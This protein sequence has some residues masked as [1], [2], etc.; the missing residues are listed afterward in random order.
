[1]VNEACRLPIR[2]FGYLATN[3][4]AKTTFG[5]NGV[6]ADQAMVSHFNRGEDIANNT[7][8]KNFGVS[9]AEDLQ[10]TQGCRLASPEVTYHDQG[11]R[12]QI[13]N[14]NQ[15]R[16]AW[17]SRDVRYVER[18]GNKVRYC[19]VQFYTDSRQIVTLSEYKTFTDKFQMGLSAAGITAQNVQS[20]L[21]GGWGPNHAHQMN[22]DNPN[23]KGVHSVLA[24]Y[25]GHVH[26]LMVWL[27]SPRPGLYGAI[28]TSGEI[29][30]PENSG[31]MTICMVKKMNADGRY[32]GNLSMKFNI[33][34][35]PS[36]VNHATRLL[37]NTNNNARGPI[38][39]TDTMI[40]GLDV[41]NKVRSITRA[42]LIISLDSC[43][44]WRCYDKCS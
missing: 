1:M 33:K 4:W 18:P 42:E 16:A 15:D 24:K 26:V 35:G 25:K 41:V 17:D 40:V 2:N 37:E 7:K 36:T 12:L 3:G 6:A 10:T 39:A 32:F 8:L 19:F 9:A 34:A 22:H 27:T 14:R 28:K 43:S 29:N 13:S 23:H 44:G 5:M 31:V 11:G 20:S 21:G 30:L 38:L